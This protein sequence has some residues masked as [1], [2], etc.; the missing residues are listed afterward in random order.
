MA[1]TR[2][3]PRKRISSR[4]LAD[5]NPGRDRSPVAT[6]VERT[7]K[8]GGLTVERHLPTKRGH[9]GWA[10]IVDSKGKRLGAAPIDKDGYI[11]REMMVARL[12]DVDQGDRDGRRRNVLVDMSVDAKR[13]APDKDPLQFTWFVHPNELDATGVDSSTADWWKVPVDPAKYGFRGTKTPTRVFIKAN[14]QQ[15]RAW[16]MAILNR[17]FTAAERKLMD[18][19]II[20]VSPIR[21]NA[22][23]YYQQ[24]HGAIERYSYLWYD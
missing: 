8:V 6:K 3:V 18:G 15:E 21:G 23:G 13:I 10:R 20:D 16:V 7:I 1:T 9:L 17:N 24:A 2:L 14:T 11:P 12:M 5:Q 19:L 4:R 22:A